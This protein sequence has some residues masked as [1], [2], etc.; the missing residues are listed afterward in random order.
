MEEELK[1]RE[2]TVADSTLI[3]ELAAQVFPQTYSVILSP[4]QLDYMFDMMYSLQSLRNQMEMEHQKFFLIYKKNKPCGYL[5]IEKVN[6][7]FYRFQKI[8]CLPEYQKTG[9]GRFIVEQG[10]KYLS[11]N[12]QHPFTI[13]LFVNR[14]NPAYGFYK[15]V[16]FTTFGTRD[17][18]IGNGYFMNDYIMRKE[19]N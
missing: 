13:E 17:E 2:A 14:D 7:S 1:F 11:E 3:N 18:P 4:K 12:C 15:H 19:I 10:I 8:Y 5:S 9:V 16:G 6:G